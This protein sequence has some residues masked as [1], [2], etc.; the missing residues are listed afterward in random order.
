LIGT[1]TIFLVY[2]LG[3]EMFNKKTGI[4]SATI[5]AFVP[6]HV[7]YSGRILNDVLVTF[8]I[9]LAF[10]FFWKG[11]EKGNEKYKIFWGIV[12]GIGLLARYTMLWI[13]PIFPIYLWI[14]NKSLNF[15]KDKYLWYA[16]IGFF[17]VLIPWFV[18]GYFEYGNIFGG[19]L[20]GFKGA[21]YWG[22]NQSWMFFFQNHRYI[23][24]ISG[25]LFVLSL[26]GISYTKDYKKR[27]V[28][29]LL[30]WSLLY[31]IM[32]VI[33]PHKEERFVIPI[34]PAISLIIGYSL[35]KIKSYKKII[36]GIIL[37]IL[38]WSC[39]SILVH[40]K[41]ISSNT[42]TECFIETM[43]FLKK[44][45]D[46]YITVSE[47]PPIVRYFTN[48]ES[49]FYPDKIT[50]ESLKEVSN[51]TNKTVYFIFNKLN[52]GFETDKWMKLNEILGEDYGL[53]FKC[54]EDPEVNFVYSNKLN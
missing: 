18:Y 27:E 7:I 40:D 25:I 43:N 14:K 22:G 48:T 8:F 33:M 31:F 19:F 38:L 51:S 46:N 42:N 4:I 36:L 37:I 16:I 26:I 29:I 15:L 11:F 5:I 45:G 6:I 10:F 35:N 50:E 3:K 34:I 44:Q 39:L 9:T 32:L 13:I 21:A 30:I 20:H 52:S 49:S 2:L 24:S 54:P 41:N 47:N 12:L 17:V 1:L 28:Y 53:K 23:F